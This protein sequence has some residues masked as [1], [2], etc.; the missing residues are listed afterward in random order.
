VSLVVFALFEVIL[1]AWVFGMDRGWAEIN[2]G[3]DLRPP[4]VYRFIIKYITPLILVVVF[5]GSLPGIWAKITAPA[6]PYVHG[7]RLL[8]LGLYVGIALLVRKAY[9]KRKRHGHG[10]V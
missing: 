7:S 9:L 4:Q 3:A 8:L 2:M 5:F 6:S 10:L 1:F